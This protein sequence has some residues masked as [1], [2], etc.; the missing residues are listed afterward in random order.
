MNLRHALRTSDLARAAGISVQQVRNYERLAL[1][2]PAERNKSGYRLYTQRHLATL[3]TAR[4]LIGGYGWQR[5]PKIMQALHRDDLSAA[6]AIIDSRHAGLASKRREY[7]QTLTARHAYASR[8]CISGSRAF[9][10]RYATEAAAIASTMSNRCS[11]CAWWFYSERPATVSP[12]SVSSGRDGIR[13]TRKGDCGGR[14]EAQGTGMDRLKVHRSPGL[15]PAICAGVLWRAP[16]QRLPGGYSRGRFSIRPPFSEKPFPLV[17]FR[18]RASV[19]L[20]RH[21]IIVQL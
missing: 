9:C 7:E 16:R 12:S 10:I 11:A 4:G 3:K 15:L 19:L 13:P 6:L 1:L 18:R 5:I 21:A 20:A 8:P 2:P 14:E 17:F